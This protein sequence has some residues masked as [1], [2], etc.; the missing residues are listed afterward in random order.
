MKEN[1]IS[2]LNVVDYV[3]T[4]A[5]LCSCNNKGFIGVLKHWLQLAD[6]SI[7]TRFSEALACQQI[8]E[9][10]TCNHIAKV[11]HDIHLKYGSTDKVNKIISTVTDNASNF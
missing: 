7:L 11:L 6:N 3:C 10:H 2:C 9:S 5:D 8:Q 4:T 1:L